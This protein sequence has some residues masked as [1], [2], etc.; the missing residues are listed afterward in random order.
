MFHFFI[1]R[2]A[3]DIEPTEEVTE[4]TA[5]VAYKLLS[6][7]SEGRHKVDSLKIILRAEGKKNSHNLSLQCSEMKLFLF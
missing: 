1:C 6:E 4:Y 3:I 7:G 2:F 5:T